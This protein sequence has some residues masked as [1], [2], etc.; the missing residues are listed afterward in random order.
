MLFDFN[1]TCNLVMPK[2]VLKML[3]LVTHQKFRSWKLISQKSKMEYPH[4]VFMLKFKQGILY[5][6]I[7]ER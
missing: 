1:K 5:D 4:S 2:M 3:K 7:T 6:H